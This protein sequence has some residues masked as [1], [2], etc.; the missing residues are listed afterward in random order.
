MSVPREPSVR[1]AVDI[2]A[3]NLNA[4]VCWTRERGEHLPRRVHRGGEVGLARESVA[5]EM[6]DR[7]FGNL[8]FV[9]CGAIPRDQDTADG[10]QPASS[11]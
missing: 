3:A 10:P 7:D 2:A 5:L 4:L 9:G 6:L 1:F 11:I 8:E